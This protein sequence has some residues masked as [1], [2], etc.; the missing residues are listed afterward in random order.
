M[1]TE[2]IDNI[3]MTPSATAESSSTFIGVASLGIVDYSELPSDTHW[4][5]FSCKYENN[6]NDETQIRVRDTT[7]SSTHACISVSGTSPSKAVATPT[8]H[9]ASTQVEYELQVKAASGATSL[10]PSVRANVWIGER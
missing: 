4:V 2:P 5:W 6:N 8:S 7:N 10:V 1:T 3:G 9:S